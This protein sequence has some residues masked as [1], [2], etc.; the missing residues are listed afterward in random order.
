MVTGRAMDSL[1]VPGR[2]K[3]SSREETKVRELDWSRGQ[4]VP[5]THRHTLTFIPCPL[6]P[7]GKPSDTVLPHFPRTAGLPQ[8]R[9]WVT[10]LLSP[11]WSVLPGPVD[12]SGTLRAIY[13]DLQCGHST[14]LC[15][16][17]RSYE[18]KTRLPDSITGSGLDMHHL[19][20]PKGDPGAQQGCSEEVGPGT[21]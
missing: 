16:S 21:P 7:S 20:E 13:R 12:M 3:G 8:G 1:I 15:M 2:G 14:C 4:F 17:Q 9:I 5:P 19:A 6:S 10:E 18:S 11:P